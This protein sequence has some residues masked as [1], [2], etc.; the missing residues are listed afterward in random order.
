MLRLKLSR[1]PVS[2]DQIGRA[3]HRVGKRRL[4]NTPVLPAQIVIGG[5]HPGDRRW[6]IEGMIIAARAAVGGGIPAVEPDGAFEGSVALFE[7]I[8]LFDPELRKGYEGAED[9]RFANPD[10]RQGRRFDQ[11]DLDIGTGIPPIKHAHQRAGS[12]PEL[13]PPIIVNRFILSFTPAHVPFGPHRPEKGQVP[14][15]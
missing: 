6:R 11:L 12:Q 1:R 5:A 7:K 9:G 13:P 2:I 3:A 14:A 10:N 4:H 8:E 15:H